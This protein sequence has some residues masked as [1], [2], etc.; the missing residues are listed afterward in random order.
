MDLA[1]TLLDVLNFSY[2]SKFFGRSLLEP[3]QGNDFALLSH[4]RDVALLRN[5]RLALL[6]IKMEN[7]LWDRDSVDGKFTAL[8]I[9]SDSTLLLD[10]IAY[11]QTAYRLYAQKLLTP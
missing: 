6:G 9:E 4:N 1:P 7:G 5:N 2:S 8:P 10:A 11:Y 3:H